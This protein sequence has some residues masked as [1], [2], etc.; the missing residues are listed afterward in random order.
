MEYIA[1]MNDEIFDKNHEIDQYNDHTA[2]KTDTF[3]S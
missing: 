3:R 1:I 2:N